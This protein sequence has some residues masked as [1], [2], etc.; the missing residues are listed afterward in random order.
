MTELTRR[1]TVVCY[2]TALSYGGNQA[3]S[4]NADIRKCGCGVIAA[5]DLLLYLKGQE[6]PI[7]EAEYDRYADTLRRRYF[8]LM[9]P[10]GM[11]ALVLLA[12]MNRL[13]KKLAVPLKASW[14]GFGPDIWF[15]V[16]DMLARNIPAIMAV[17]PNFPLVWQQ[18]RLS[19]YRKTA[20]EEYTKC[21]AVKAHF[22]TV[23]AMDAV[24]LRVSTWGVKLY[25]KREEFESYAAK[26]SGKILSGVLYI[27]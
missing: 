11:N 10:L 23:T 19:L 18:N 21:S 8:P 12:G 20:A 5:L 27:K 24:W 22:L 13:L 17:G 4:R 2:G 16:A 25:I 7:E 6:A 26:Q 1:Y 9:P 15:K 3:K 14:V